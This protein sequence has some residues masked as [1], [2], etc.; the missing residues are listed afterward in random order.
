MFPLNMFSVT[1]LFT[2]YV[3]SKHVSRMVHGTRINILHFSCRM[4]K[5]EITA[6]VDH[7]QNNHVSTM[8]HTV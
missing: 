8:I 4:F 7:A 1:A 6:V 3:S 5:L 2:S